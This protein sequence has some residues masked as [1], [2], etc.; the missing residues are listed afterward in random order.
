[1]ALAA[2]ITREPHQKSECPSAIIANGE[3]QLKKSKFLTVIHV[4]ACS[5]FRHSDNITS[6]ASA[7]HSH[8]IAISEGYQHLNP[9]RC[10]QPTTKQEVT[11]F[12]HLEHTQAYYWFL[13]EYAHPLE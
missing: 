6:L 3:T 2:V 12:S 10:L 9:P 13:K 11:S 8:I 7:K 5:L 1:M 4:N